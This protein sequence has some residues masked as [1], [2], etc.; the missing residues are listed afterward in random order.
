[1]QKPDQSAP[2]GAIQVHTGIPAHSAAEVLPERSTRKRG[3]GM[4]LYVSNYI[5]EALLK[6]ADRAGRFA[7][8]CADDAISEWLMQRGVDVSLTKGDE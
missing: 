3:P 4:Q 8:S 2:K 6:Y 7:K 5:K 1:M